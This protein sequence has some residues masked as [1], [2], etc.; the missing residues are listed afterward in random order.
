MSGDLSESP[1]KKSSAAGDTPKVST[2]DDINVATVD[3]FDPSDARNAP[4]PIP[5]PSAG[6]GTPS[7]TTVD[8][9]IPTTVVESDTA[10][11]VIDDL[12]AE[13]TAESA[14]E[15]ECANCAGGFAPD[16]CGHV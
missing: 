5:T 12:P 15:P 2:V 8:N 10:T 6:I 7:L 4:L 13:G 16:Y 3:T 14:K 11:G 1:I 9:T